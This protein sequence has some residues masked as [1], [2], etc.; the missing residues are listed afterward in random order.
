MEHK[1]VKLTPNHHYIY[2]GVRYNTRLECKEG[3]ARE[4]KLEK[5]NTTLFNNLLALGL[6]QKFE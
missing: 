2:K 6:V 3:I 4:G 5:V 1:K